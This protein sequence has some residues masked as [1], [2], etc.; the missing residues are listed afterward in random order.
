MVSYL[1]RYGG[2]YEAGD[3]QFTLDDLHV[4]SIEPTRIKS[5]KCLQS[6]SSALDGCWN[7][8]ASPASDSEGE[9]ESSGSSSEDSSSCSD[10]EEEQ[11]DDGN[12]RNP[13][14]YSSLKDFFAA[15]S[16]KSSSIDLFL[17]EHF[18]EEAKQQLA[19]GSATNEKQLRQEAFLLAKA[20]WAA[21]EE[22]SKI[23]SMRL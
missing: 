13:A 23:D 14:R 19:S 6:V 5:L 8:K 16:T 22:L 4:A 11:S 3:K 2:I 1:L 18:L 12:T 15:N 10:S 21:Q 7:I 9:T 20:A 17:D